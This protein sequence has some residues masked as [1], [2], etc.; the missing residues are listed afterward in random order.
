M[1]RDM[2]TKDKWVYVYKD[3]N[4]DPNSVQPPLAKQALGIAKILKDRGALRRNELLAEMQNFVK[5]KQKGGANRI[6]AYYQGLLIRRNV[7]EVRKKPE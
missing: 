2:S 1:S 5:T 3:V 4:L 6:L 7:I